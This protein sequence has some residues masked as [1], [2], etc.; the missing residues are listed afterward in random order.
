MA[1]INVEVVLNLEGETLNTSSTP[2]KQQ[3]A[4]NPM[5]NL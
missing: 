2:F 1:G 4:V 5:T 3:S